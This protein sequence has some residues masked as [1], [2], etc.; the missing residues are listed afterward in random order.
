MPDTMSPCALYVWNASQALSLYGLGAEESAAL[1]VL[2]AS[3]L[4]YRTFRERYLLVWI[5]GWATFFLSKWTLRGVEGASAYLTALSQAEFILASCLFAA[6][7]LVFTQARKLLLPLA[8]STVIIIGYAIA[9][10]LLWPDS[11]RLRLILEVCY[12]VVILTAALQLILFRWARAEIGPWILSASLVCLH[13]DRAP[14][15]N[16]LPAGF[17]VV[18]ATMLGL[19]M[20]LIVLDESKTRTRRLG[21]VNALTSSIMRSQQHGPMMATALEELMRLMGAKAAW[22][23]LADGENMVIVQQ[24]GLSQEFL[25]HHMA[26]PMDDGFESTL[27]GG[28]PLRLEMSQM[29]PGGRERL[30]KEGFHHCLLVPVMGKKTV[31][32]TLTLGSRRRMRYTPDEMEFLSTSANQLGLA[33]ENLRLLEQI[34]RSH[35]QWMNTF[36]SIQDAVLLHDAEYTVMKANRAM[37]ERVALAPAAVIGK[38]CEEALPRDHGEWSKCPYCVADDQGFHEGPDPCFGGFSL[39]STSSYVDQASTQRGTIHVIRDVTDRKL[40]EE[41]YRQ[42]F[43]QMQ[44]GVFVATPDGDLLD[45]N[46]ALVRMLG[47]GNRS[48]VLALNLE[49]DVYASSAEREKFRREIKLHNFVR[50]FEVG[51]RMQDGTLLHAMESSF[52]TH[53]AQ[54]N[55][56]RYQGFLQDITEKRR[57]EDEIRRRNRE[58]NAL[59]AMAVIATQSFDLDEVLN[60]TLRQ[61]LT[62]LEAT[63]G[64]V[65][66]SDSRDDTFR[67]RANWGQRRGDNSRPPE[68]TFP[69]GFGNLVT[70]SRTEVITPEFLPHLPASVLEFISAESVEAWIWVLLWSKEKPIGMMGIRRGE[71]RG[72]SSN[73]ENL[74]VA[75]GRQLATTIEKAHL[76]EQACRAY[77]DMRHAQEQL[78]QSEKMSAL[79]QLIAGVAH[80]LNNPLTAILGYA[81]LL[82]TEGLGERAADFVS[83]LFKQAQRT[84]RVVQNLLSFARQRKPQKHP[85]A[86][87]KVLEETLALRDYDLKVTRIQLRREVD[88]AVPAVTGDPHQIEQVFLNIINNAVDAMLESGRNGVLT[89]RVFSQ[90]SYVTVEFEDNGPGI[91][92]PNRI[93]DPFYTTKSVGKGTGLGLSIC[94]GIIKEHGGEVSARNRPQGGAII[95]VRLPA[96]GRVV[97]P[98]KPVLAPAH[99]AAIE[100]RVLVAEDEEAVL[101][102]ERDVLIGA[103]AR[104]VALTSTEEAKELLRKESFDGLIMAGKQ[105]GGGSPPEVVRWLAQNCP[106]MEKHVLFTFSTV[107]DPETRAFLLENNIPSLVKPFE[108][109]DLIAQVRR[110]LQKA[111]AAAAG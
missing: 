79:G 4:L 44:E 66:L 28:V 22:F 103:G 91:K 82:E 14:F 33:V 16:R 74:L 83:K 47:Y 38:S 86:V 72:H 57:A 92:E 24:I 69:E 73:D 60:V 52:A 7:V 53:D 23:R 71:A 12:H 59:N 84:H 37:L 29:D 77:D 2:A 110:L 105:P 104:V 106:G 65:Y 26:V 70:R 102:F 107:A 96:A 49:T 75:V 93:F 63:T 15:A 85:M 89:V 78:L 19:S 36:D 62:L 94:Y 54:G 101:E 42:L 99:E 3:L 61:V 76:Y 20:L 108:V 55:I 11:F 13:L 50:S 41:K 111:H 46:D 18:T 9:C 43:E 39:V 81:Q 87:P 35:R 98:E 8:V 95:T 21:V 34:L 80:E 100:G 90:D 31:I 27:V 56:E 109:A 48:E 10:G 5:L 58:L 88:A 68:V 17:D 67:R 51:L 40:A 32:G 1:I 6:A 25:Q 64:V 30:A 45:C 97:S